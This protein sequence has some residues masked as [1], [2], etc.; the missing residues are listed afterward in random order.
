M[1]SSKVKYP[2]A[3][4]G[5]FHPRGIRQMSAEQPLGSLLAGIKDRQSPYGGCRF[6]Q[7]VE[8]RM[9][10]RAV[11][12]NKIVLELFIDKATAA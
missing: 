8:R 1:R 2:A 5:V 7:S 12:K 3:C 6:W 4:C 11:M 9:F 10:D